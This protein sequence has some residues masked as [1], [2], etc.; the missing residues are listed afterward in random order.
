MCVFCLLLL[1]TLL[2]TL[3]FQRIYCSFPPEQKELMLWGS[4][5]SYTYIYSSCTR[6]TSASHAHT[7]PAFLFKRAQ[8]DVSNRGVE[9]CRKH[10]C[11]THVRTWALKRGVEDT[12]TRVLFAKG[13]ALRTALYTVRGVHSVE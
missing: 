5:Y 3:A 7:P 6:I 12:T 10:A 4:L 11:V 2:Y 13:I 1:N 8:I 9:R